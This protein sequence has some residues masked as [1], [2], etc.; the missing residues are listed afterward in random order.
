[1]ELYGDG[2][3]FTR[4]AD[5]NEGR[6]MVDGSRFVSAGDIRPGWELLLPE[7]EGGEERRSHADAP[8]AV[9]VAPGDTLSKIAE[10]KLGDPDRYPEIF[11]LNR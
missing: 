6:V 1:E 4:I 8:R 9:T 10:D 7:D 3:Q 11:D 5:L 2:A